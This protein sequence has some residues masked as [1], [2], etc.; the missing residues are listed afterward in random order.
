MATQ[1]MYARIHNR[2]NIFKT[3]S[4]QQVRQ[5]FI[6]SMMLEHSPRLQHIAAHTHITQ[7][8]TLRNTQAQVSPSKS[9]P[10]SYNFQP[11]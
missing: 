8:N 4:N 11:I 5:G 2:V 7:L 1:H 10:S 3:L 6:N 9:S